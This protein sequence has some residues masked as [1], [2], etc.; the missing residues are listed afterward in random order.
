MLI[1]RLL[2]CVGVLV[3]ALT[4]CGA[5]ATPQTAG[6]QAAAAPATVQ[7]SAPPAPTDAAATSVPATNSAPAMPAMPPASC[8]VTLPLAPP[9]TPPPPYP[10]QAPF[11]G[12]CWYGT[13]SLWTMA[14]VNGVWSLLHT[15]TGY[16]EKVFWWRKGYSV[17][18][19]PF[20]DL[21]VTGRRLDAPPPPLSAS[22]A[23]NA[24]AG[25]I[26]SAMLVGVD[27]PT[28]GCWEITG[29]YKG[30]DLSFVVWVAP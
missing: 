26:K 8:P 11:K 19:E 14:P 21:S 29:Q 2:I 4:A 10:A 23:T 6:V 27:F 5:P 16:T 22:Y 25:D 20:P 24:F 12:H 15:D 17:T 18:E 1:R 28:F 13:A 9:F 3:L 30:T 7:P